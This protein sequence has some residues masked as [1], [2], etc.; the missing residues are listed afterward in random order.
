MKGSE[1][2]RSVVLGFGEFD[3][4]RLCSAIELNGTIMFELIIFRMFDLVPGSYSELKIN[5]VAKRRE[6]DSGL[7]KLVCSKRKVDSLH[8]LANNFTM[9]RS[10][11][12]C[13][14]FPFVGLLLMANSDQK[15]IY[16][17]LDFY[18][19][20]PNLIRQY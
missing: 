16:P 6:V 7:I 19:F 5:V 8:K 11:L 13:Q 1:I 20:A 10:V 14:G 17:F 12:L 9:R 2:A 3:L 18:K 4:V 15:P